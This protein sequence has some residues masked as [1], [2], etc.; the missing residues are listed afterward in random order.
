MSV[1]PS[2]LTQQHEYSLDT[3]TGSD[4]DDFESE[5]HLA[6][7]FYSQ[8]AQ[9]L[10]RIFSDA[11]DFH[12]VLLEKR[13]STDSHTSTSSDYK[14][15][16]KHGD[17]FLELIGKDLDAK[18]DSL[19]SYAHLARLNTASDGWAHKV[20]PDEPSSYEG[21]TSGSVTPSESSQEATSSSHSEEEA[22]EDWK[23]PSDEVLALI[24][25]G[26]GALTVGDEKEEL[27]I[28]ADS[29]IYRDILILVSESICFPSYT[30]HFGSFRV[31]Y[32]SQRIE[33]PSMHHFSLQDPIAF[34]P[35]KY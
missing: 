12:Q 29:A 20:F 31:L 35:S 11:A 14:P 18:D 24:Q 10:S 3:S 13:P 26:C 7:H 5:D 23:L 22:E 8:D 1:N 25:E 30:S 16:H 2:D 17:A 32:I 21:D 15:I 28:E 6:P 34:L 9:S 4:S 27:L 19:G 33:F